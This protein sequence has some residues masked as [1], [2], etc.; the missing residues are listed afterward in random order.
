M[1]ESIIVAP[2]EKLPP[3]LR[4]RLVK[5]PEICGVYKEIKILYSLEG[6]T[7]KVFIS[8]YGR[9]QAVLG[10][11]TSNFSWDKKGDR[12][13]SSFIEQKWFD[14]RRLI[15]SISPYTKNAQSGRFKLKIMRAH[16]HC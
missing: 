14:G 2:N 5:N 3:K 4:E 15:I 12:R 9:R 8:L 6:S 11:V 1:A 13:K 10:I 16:G 7:F